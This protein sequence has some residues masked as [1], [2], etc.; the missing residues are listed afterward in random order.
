VNDVLGL[1]DV[2]AE[3]E[4]ASPVESIDVVARNLAKRFGATCGPSVSTSS[5]TRRAAATGPSR[6]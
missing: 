3:A 4:D 1:G 5:R 6:R 2:L